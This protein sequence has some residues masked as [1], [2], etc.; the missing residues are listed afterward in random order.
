MC[1]FPIQK[2]VGTVAIFF[3]FT[4]CMDVKTSDFC[5]QKKHIQIPQNLSKYIALYKEIFVGFA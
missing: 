3:Y 4:T 1:P 5:K 2:V